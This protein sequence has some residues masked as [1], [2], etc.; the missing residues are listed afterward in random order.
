M[1]EQTSTTKNNTPYKEGIKRDKV[2]VLE[3]QTQ[4]IIEKV[5]LS[6]YLYYNTQRLYARYILIQ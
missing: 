2:S 3:T 1:Q 4:T 5:P 6:R